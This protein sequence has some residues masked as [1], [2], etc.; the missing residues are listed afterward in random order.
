MQDVSDA[1][2]EALRIDD[3]RIAAS[4]TAGLARA[5]AGS[6]TSKPGAAAPS[7]SAAARASLGGRRAGA[8]VS[9]SMEVEG[10]ELGMVA[11]GAKE[12]RP[13]KKRRMFE[14]SDDDDED[15]DNESQSGASGVAGK[16]CEQQM[17]SR[18]AEGSSTSPDETRLSD[19]K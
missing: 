12:A 1:A 3:E 4:V 9:R 10:S 11:A 16:G 14:L 7:A 17:A 13:A 19:E 6:S 2:K 15:E 5:G 8:D 18:G